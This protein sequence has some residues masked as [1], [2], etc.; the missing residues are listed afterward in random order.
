MLVALWWLQYA[1]AFVVVDVCLFLL[2]RDYSTNIAP[3]VGANSVWVSGLVA[4]V[5]TILI[6]L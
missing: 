3:F 6:N 5:Q 4:S 1:I 2:Y